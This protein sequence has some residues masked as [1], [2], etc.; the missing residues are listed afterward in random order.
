MK[1]PNFANDALSSQSV[2][3][4]VVHHKQSPLDNTRLDQLVY[5]SVIK[6]GRLSYRRS[7]S[8]IDY[9]TETRA[10]DRQK[11]IPKQ[12]GNPVHSFPVYFTL[13]LYHLTR[14]RHNR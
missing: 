14:D 13:A 9:Y 3:L 2:S 5:L 1:S 4:V 12:V 10:S 8:R 7:Y 6:R 11:G